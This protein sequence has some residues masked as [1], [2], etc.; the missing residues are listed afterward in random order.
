MRL[1]TFLSDFGLD[2]P[3]PAAM[4]AVAAGICDAR[5]IDI[6]HAVPPHAVRTGAYLL[7]SVAP[8]CPAGTVHCAVVDPGVGTD[9]APLAVASAG[10]VFVGPDNGLLLPAAKR[11]GSP[12][13]YRLANPAY[14]RE[15]VSATFHGR[16]VFAPAAAHLAAGAAI[17]SVGPPVRDYVDLTLERAEWDGAALRGEVLWV[18]PFG[19]ILTTIPGAAL[20][21][22]PS[23]RAVMID[24]PRGGIRATAGH[25]FGDVPPGAAVV[26]AGSD[27]LVEIALNRGR[28][29]DVLPAAPGDPVR[30]R[31]V[32]I[33]S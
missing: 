12:D 3:Y 10:H 7:W 24:V 33:G 29:A 9:R 15:S 5:F 6:S 13:V 32:D 31:P 18:D 8:A 23:G 27:G 11:L 2:S 4:K 21:R 1:L 19:N 28:A 22:I 14:R 25:T 20:A 17:G 30:F 26:L 16:D